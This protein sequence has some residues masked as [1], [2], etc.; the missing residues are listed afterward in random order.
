MENSFKRS[1]VVLTL[2]MTFIMVH[3]AWSGI[4]DVGDETVITGVLYECEP[5]GGF[6]VDTSEEIIAIYGMGPVSYWEDEGVEFPQV[7]EEVTIWA[8][9]ITF[10]DDTEKLVAQSV[11]VDGDGVADIELR[12]EDGTPL[13]R[14]RGKGMK[15]VT[16]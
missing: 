6:Q 2:V 3:T 12:A 11:D 7:G 8:V 4:V 14:Q 15:K 9:V 10:S 13:W 5:G 1:F 16:E